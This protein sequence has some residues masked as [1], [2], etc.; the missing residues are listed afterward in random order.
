MDQW[1][2]KIWDLIYLLQNN[3]KLWTMVQKFWH[4]RKS[5]CYMSFSQKDKHSL[6]NYQVSSLEWFVKFYVYSYIES[7][8]HLI[9]VLR[10]TELPWIIT[11]ILWLIF[12]RQISDPISDYPSFM[13]SNLASSVV[14]ESNAKGCARTWSSSDW[15]STSEVCTPPS[16]S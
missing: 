10:P 9:R 13:V 12:K 16:K 5:R 15:T 6:C 2:V 11:C 4:F 8:L 3:M 14:I 7:Y 1:D